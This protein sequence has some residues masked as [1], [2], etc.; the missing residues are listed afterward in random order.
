[1]DENKYMFP[2]IKGIQA[3]TEYYVSMVPLYVVPK[4]FS[5][6]GN[7]LPAEMRAQRIINKSRIPEIKNYIL[8]NPYSYVFS[9]LTVS[10]DGPI[11]FI[12][13]NEAQNNSLGTLSISMSARLLLNDGQHRKAAI[14][15]A[16]QEKP[17]LRFETISIVFYHDLGL[18]KSQQMFSDLNRYAIRPTKSINVLFDSRDKYAVILCELIE[19]L[20]FFKGW[21]EKEKSTLSNRSKALYTLS[22][23]YHGTKAL[24]NNIDITDNDI[25]SIVSQFWT[26]VYNNT[27]EWNAV[28]NGISHASEIR[29]KSL[30]GH[31]IYLVAVSN[32]GNE[33]LRRKESFSQYFDK[34]ENINFDKSNPLWDGTIVVNNQISGARVNI[35]NLTNI[36]GKELFPDWN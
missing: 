12:P 7:D 11:E 17:S 36:I 6:S 32:I 15:A 1:M 13:V 3:G 18:Q 4:L 28:I 26:E 8:Q 9:A 2:A 27:I 20:P 30:C 25:K 33:I 35:N 10:I 14:E 21:V 5:F 24:L 31:S 29:K 19:E 22:G 16:L 23:L 34:L